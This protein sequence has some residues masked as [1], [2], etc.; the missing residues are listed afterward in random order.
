M[1]KTRTKLLYFHGGGLITG[2][3][4]DYPKQYVDQ[5]HRLNYEFIGFDYPLAPATSL[6]EILDAC[7]TFVK[8][9]SQD[10][11]VLMGRS[12]GAYLVIN[13]LENLYKANEKLPKKVVLFYGYENFDVPAFYMKKKYPTT[14]LK[15]QILPYYDEQKSSDPLYHRALLYLYARQEGIWSEII[16]STSNLTHRQ[17]SILT[18]DQMPLTFIA[19]SAN[20]QDVPYAES[21]K[22]NQKITG[23]TLKTVYYLD[24]EFDL[25]I[26]NPQTVTVMNELWYFLAQ[27]PFQ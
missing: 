11:Y 13:T 12:A 20:D 26:N 9:Y 27:E 21:K 7:T 24:H 23:S 25:E 19:H 15:S 8:Q 22:L 3:K 1:Q 2:H 17:C 14:I 4:N 16:K 10:D 6:E 5:L 18:S